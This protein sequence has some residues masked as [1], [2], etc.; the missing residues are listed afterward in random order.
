MWK[1]QRRILRVFFR[2]LNHSTNQLLDR[3]FPGRWIVKTL[4]LPGVLS[5]SIRPLCAWTICFAMASPS[6]VP[7]NSRLLALSTYTWQ[8]WI[9]VSKTSLIDPVSN[10]ISSSVSSRSILDKVRR[11]STMA[12]SRFMC[13]MTIPKKRSISSGF[14]TVPSWRVSTKPLICSLFFY[15]WQIAGMLPLY[16]PYKPDILYISN[17]EVKW[18]L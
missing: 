16:K 15:S 9:A 13:L 4:P 11:S 18:R 2:H 14:S 7:P 17:G 3:V 12:S 5:T 10:F 6:P 1:S 8:T